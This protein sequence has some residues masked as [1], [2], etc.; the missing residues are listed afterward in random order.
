MKKLKQY[1]K[2]QN[3]IVALGITLAVMFV[4]S[5]IVL[6]LVFVYLNR[7]EAARNLGLSEQAYFAAESGVEDA[8]LRV[9][10]PNKSL[11]ASMPY[12]ISLGNINADVTV[13][14]F[15]GYSKEII[16]DGDSR[17]RLR[18][19]YAFLAIDSESASFFH[20]AQVGE[21][22]LIM[23]N[24]S[25]VIGSVFSNGDIDGTNQSSITGDAF[26]AG[27]SSIDDTH[28]GGN[29]YAADI[30][31][32]TL[33]DGNANADTLDTCTIGGD[34]YYDTSITSCTVTGSTTQEAY[35]PLA[36]E[37][38]PISDAKIDE[39]KQTALDGGVIS[40][41]TNGNYIPA[42]QEIL[43]P[44]K[45]ECNLIIDG[46]K[47]VY[48]AGFVWVEG[49]IVLQNQPTLQIEPGFGQLSTAVIASHPGL[50]GSKGTISIGNNSSIEGSGEEGSY[51][52]MISTNTS[53]ESGGGGT[54]AISIQNGSSSSI[55]YAPHGKI[56][57]SNNVALVEVTGYELALSNSA[58]I[59]Y[60]QGLA[61]VQFS[62]GPQAGFSILNWEER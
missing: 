47:T 11:P 60:E 2:E 27:T 54:T 33:V 41:C 4:G 58:Q 20:G 12:S 28:V 35:T 8:L 18:R 24:G 32:N 3:G 36:A 19:L 30:S 51:L 59:Q 7:L 62:S 6:S 1:I 50:P 9:L 53:A 38:M 45:I 15:I 31:G 37:N 26:A 17:N 40:T 13:N 49:D 25:G 42:D 34:A 61:N 46:N 39:W 22:G 43:G 10:D 5:I 56:D 16:S 44:V 57:I 14:E 23:S 29:A 21:G 48:V 55:F 52:M